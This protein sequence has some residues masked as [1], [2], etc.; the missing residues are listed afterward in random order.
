MPKKPAKSP[1]PSWTLMVY[2]AGDNNLTEEMT[3][4]LQELKDT[5]DQLRADG[6]G[7]RINVVAHFDPRGSRG[8]R[9]DFA[10]PGPINQPPPPR[11]LDGHLDRYEAMIYTDAMVEARTEKAS[12]ALRVP[13]DQRPGPAQQLSAFLRE[14]VKRLPVAREYVLVLSG[15]GSGAVGDFLIDLDPETSLSIP[16]LARILADGREYYAEQYRHYEDDGKTPKRIAILGMDSCLMS[17]AEVCYEV[18]DQ[19][20]FLVASE[21]WVANNGWPYHRVLEAMVNR[22]RPRTDVGAVARQV[23]NNYSSFYRDYEI[24]GLSTDIAV[25]DLEAFRRTGKQGLVAG[26]QALAADCIP[27]LE[28]LFAEDALKVLG[29]QAAAPGRVRQAQR[30]VETLAREIASDLLPGKQRKYLKDEL[31]WRRRVT[32]YP[33]AVRKQELY[34]SQ[35]EAFR[36]LL[37]LLE[38]RYDLDDR[39]LGPRLHACNLEL[40]NELA[41]PTTYARALAVARVRREFDPG[42]QEALRLIE[43]GE[44]QGRPEA[45]RA[46]GRLQ[47]LHQIRW[48]LDLHELTARLKPPSPRDQS[49]RNALVAARWQAQSFKAGVYVDLFDLC[50]CLGDRLPKNDPV[51]PL[52]RKVLRSITGANGAVVL[53]HYSGPAFQ[54]AHGLSVYFPTEAVDYAPE[55]ENLALAERTGWGRFLRAYLRLTRRARR[56]EST[57]WNQAAAQVLRFGDLEVDPL[58]TTSLEAKIIGVRQPREVEGRFRADQFRAGTEKK[59]RAAI[60]SRPTAVAA[61]GGHRAGTEKKIRAGTEKK[62]KGEGILAVWGNPP[63]GFFR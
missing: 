57:H 58:E 35:L 22:A 40:Q 28:S 16:E 43:D 56:D 31:G 50:E 15:H 32:L 33:A 44:K 12:P 17:N 20:K 54:H 49:L 23:A 63:D 62:I 42:V 30:A 48:L 24:S 8:R 6:L 45:K 27:R 53:S 36:Q 59:I 7:D 9:Y 52:C 25:C 26:L 39:T 34:V 51:L 41:N 46:R 47:K 13:A 21:G 11:N 60:G 19:A 37:D 3:W 5:A 18:R 10:P 1:R 38:R 14:Q 2:L 61:A 29:G 4:A 55:Y